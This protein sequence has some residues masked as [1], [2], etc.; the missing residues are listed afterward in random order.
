V[1]HVFLTLVRKGAKDE[2]GMKLMKDNGLV[3]ICTRLMTQDK[4]TLEL[5]MRATAD[6]CQ[7]MLLEFPRVI[8]AT[9]VP[10][11][12][13]LQSLQR[14]GGMPFYQW[15]VPASHEASPGVKTYHDIPPPLYARHARFNFPLRTITKDAAT[16]LSV[17]ANSA[18]D[19]DGLLSKIEAN[20]SLDRGQCR[21]LLA[22][23]TREFAFIQGPP[24]TGKSYL[25]LHLMRVLLDVK[26]KA[27]L[28][29]ILVV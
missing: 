16:S 11:L 24:G 9:F 2:D 18:C 5:L 23:L 12:E 19:N 4:A 22:A 13:N 3:T 21:A 8:P 15:I 1:Q 26:E 10:I 7:G 25:G 29:P 28:G 27:K 6:Q 17:E 14:T 20:T